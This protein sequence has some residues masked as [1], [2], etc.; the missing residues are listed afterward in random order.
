MS[1]SS[2]AIA[3]SRNRSHLTPYKKTPSKNIAPAA[4]SPGNWQHPRIKEITRR[5]N[6]TVFTGDNVKTIIYNIT[7]LIII[8]FIQKINDDFGPRIL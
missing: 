5:Q 4:E 3:L 7:A 8:S 1:G 6:R 2:T